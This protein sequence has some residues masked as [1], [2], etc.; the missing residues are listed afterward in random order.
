MH[1]RARSVSAHFAAP[2]HSSCVLGLRSRSQAHLA[3]ADE[4]LQQRR[5]AGR[6]VQEHEALADGHVVCARG[7]AL[8]QLE[9]HAQ[10]LARRGDTT[11]RARARCSAPLLLLDLARGARRATRRRTVRRNSREVTSVSQTRS[12]YARCA[13][14]SPLL[15]TASSSLSR[16]R[17]SSAMPIACWYC[18]SLKQLRARGRDAARQ[19]RAKLR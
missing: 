5:G 1:A 15:K 6:V 11:P 7:G 17:D 8:V 3:A 19:A 14:A 4:A 18:P 2:Q 13:G 16:R 9:Q 10:H 12:A